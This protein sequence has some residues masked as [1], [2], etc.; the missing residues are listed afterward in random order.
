MKRLLAMSISQRCQSNLPRRRGTLSPFDF[1]ATLSQKD[2][3]PVFAIR[4]AII[5]DTFGQLL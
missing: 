1:A 5:N 3:H 4:S 2:Y